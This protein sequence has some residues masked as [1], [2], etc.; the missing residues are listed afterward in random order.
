MAQRLS[1]KQLEIVRILYQA[2]DKTA[3]IQD[4]FDGISWRHYYYR[5]HHLSVILSAMLRKKAIHR[6]SKGVYSLGASTDEA[7]QVDDTVNLFN[8]I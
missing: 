8:Q 5:K 4:I 6:V 1:E 3:T 7:C 2:E